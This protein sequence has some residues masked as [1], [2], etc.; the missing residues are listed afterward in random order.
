MVT[1]REFITKMSAGLCCLAL[2]I[3]CKKE[4]GS[5]KV[6][7][8]VISDVHQD[9]QSDAPRRL[10][11]SMHQ[12]IGI[13]TLLFNWEIYPTEKTSIRS[14]K[15]GNNFPGRDTAFSVTMT[16]IILLKMLW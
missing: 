6:R 16:W 5:H 12:R 7:F 8:G 4:P 10:L 11:L 2:N 9:L 15:C 14:G 1:R 3:S 13:R